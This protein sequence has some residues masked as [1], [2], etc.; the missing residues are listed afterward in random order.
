MIERQAPEGVKWEL[1][2]R[3]EAGRRAIT[4]FVIGMG[5]WFVPFVGIVG[6]VPVLASAWM[7]IVALARHRDRSWLLLVP[8]LSV[9]SLVALLVVELTIGHD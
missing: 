7:A 1:L 3:T 2:P 4:F 9:V 6:I 8:I 5:L